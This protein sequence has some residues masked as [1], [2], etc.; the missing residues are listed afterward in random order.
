M[1]AIDFRKV[2][3][4]QKQRYEDAEQ[5]DRHQ[6]LSWSRTASTSS[7]LNA[8]AED[9]ALAELLS[10]IGVV[11]GPQLVDD[12]DQ[13][14]ALRLRP[15]DRKVQRNPVRAVPRRPG[16]DGR[17]GPGRAR[18]RPGAAPFPLCRAGRVPAAAHLRRDERGGG[19]G[20]PRRQLFHPRSQDRPAAR[21]ADRR[22]AGRLHDGAR[23]PADTSGD[24]ASSISSSSPPPPS[25]PSVVVDAA[26]IQKEFDFRKDSLSTPETRSVVQIPVKSAAQG[27]EAAARLAKGEDPGVIARSYGVQ[28]I[29]YA[30]KPVGA[31]ADRKLAA[32]AFS[33]PAGATKGPVQGDL[34]LAAVKVSKVTPAKVGDARLGAAEDRGRPPA[35][36]RARQGL[37]AQPGLR[38][39][40]HRRR[41]F[42]R[43]RPPRPASPVRDRRPVRGDGAGYCRA[44]P[45][46]T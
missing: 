26:A 44:S 24:A 40:P 11:P 27:T 32:L 7:C 20:K 33:L 16:S 34:G 8:I 29:V 3:E 6:Q 12:A 28:A 46:P 4:Q 43:P 21:G 42:A 45:R 10:R 36:G 2:F 19:A 18:R 38:R 37:S 39:R 22:P 5:T 30:D 23:R 17:T 31:I 9:Q 13:E 35:E 41:Q 25:P 1:S 14:A 15:R